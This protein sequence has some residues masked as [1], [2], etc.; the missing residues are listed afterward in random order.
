[1]LS[2]IIPTIQKKIKVLEE[3]VKILKRDNSISEIILIN[4]KIS[5][6]LKIKG[7]KIK[8]YTPTENLY[9]N[10][11]WNQGVEMAKENNVAILNDDLLIPKDFCNKIVNS[12]VFSKE[13]TGLIGLSPSIIKLFGSNVD[14]LEKPILTDKHKLEFIP[15][16]KYLN[17]GDWGSAI[18]AKKENFYRIPS[19][20]KIIYGDNYILKKNLDNKK[21]NYSISGLSIN[22]IHSSSSASSE[23]SKII[24]NDITNSKKY[25]SDKKQ[26]NFKIT[27]RNNACLIKIKNANNNETVCLKYKDGQKLYP[28][29]QLKKNLKLLSQNLSEQ[30]CSKIADAIYTL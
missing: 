14:T 25:F 26:D 18:F 5:T 9:V 13:T 30:D 19:D 12:E 20:L 11:S 24:C 8:I 21:Q 27:C 23:F 3:L 4:N 16:D 22:H 6:P 17:T 28:K 15:L 2:V 7:E 29:E 1:M 10:E